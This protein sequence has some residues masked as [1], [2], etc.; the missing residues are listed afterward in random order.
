MGA[1]PLRMIGGVDALHGESSTGEV[2]AGLAGDP[3]GGAAHTA[4]DIAEA[5]ARVEAGG[6]WARWRRSARVMKLMW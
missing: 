4:G 5:R 1:S 2:G 3:E 6:G